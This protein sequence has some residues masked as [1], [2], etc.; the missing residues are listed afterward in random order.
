MPLDANTQSYFV[1]GLL[2]DPEGPA[3][4]ADIQKELEDHGAFRNKVTVMPQPPT[5]TSSPIVSPASFLSTLTREDLEKR[6][7]ETEADLSALKVLLDAVK[8]RDKRKDKE[9]N[10]SN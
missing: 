9:R 8:A 4:P 3:L 2:V 6:I 10:G 1:G 7:A 5:P